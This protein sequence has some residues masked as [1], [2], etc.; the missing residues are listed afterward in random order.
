MQDRSRLR[1]GLYQ[2]DTCV[3]RVSLLPNEQLPPVVRWND[4]IYCLTKAGENPHIRDDFVDAIYLLE[5]PK[6]QVRQICDFEV[7]EVFPSLYRQPPIPEPADCPRCKMV[8]L[9]PGTRLFVRVVAGI[10]FSGVRR[11][12]G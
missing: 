5:A 6:D 2:H 4:D 11:R 7:D 8:N 10:S 9:L 3:G 1:I 12:I